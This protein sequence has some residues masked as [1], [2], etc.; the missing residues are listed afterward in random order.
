[1]SNNIEPS[2]IKI[3]ALE[4]EYMVILKQYEEYYIKL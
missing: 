1:M 3:E 4:K 2:I